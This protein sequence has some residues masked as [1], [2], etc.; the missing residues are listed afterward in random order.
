[1]VALVAFRPRSGNRRQ[2][3]IH[4]ATNSFGDAATRLWLWLWASRGR[5]A[6]F[7]RSQ[8]IDSQY[9]R[10]SSRFCCKALLGLPFFASSLRTTPMR[11]A[12]CREWILPALTTTPIRSQGLSKNWAT[13]L[14]LEPLN[15]S[16]QPHRSRLRNSLPQDDALSRP[17]RNRNRASRNQCCYSA[18]RWRCSSLLRAH[19]PGAESPIDVALA[20]WTSGPCELTYVAL[21]PG[22]V[23]PGAC[24]ANR[25][26]P[27][28]ESNRDVERP[29]GSRIAPTGVELRRSGTGGGTYGT[30]WHRT[31]HRGVH[32]HSCRPHT[33]LALALGFSLT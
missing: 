28:T 13:H 10:T 30:H 2:S 7:S 17:A 8:P 26:R 1:M 11:A 3:A 24:G 6:A 9:R 18:P 32:H 21:A 16:R 15:D 33:A 25:R 5:T 20:P 4:Y 27:C 14:G 31:A 12:R 22:A 29:L 23:T 19:L